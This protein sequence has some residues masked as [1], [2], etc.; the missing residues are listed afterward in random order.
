M[1]AADGDAAFDAAV[2][3]LLAGDF[4][5][6]APLFHA[7]SGADGT[8]C[9]I[10]DWDRQ[11]RFREQPAARA[12]AL[13]CACFLGCMPVVEYL[14]DHGVAA[15]GGAATGLDGLHWAVNRGQ[16]DVVRCLL[17][18]KVGL[19]TRSMYGGTPIG[20]VLWSARNEPR[21]GHLAIL[22][23]LLEAGASIDAGL[24]P[25]GDARIDALLERHGARG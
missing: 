14:L 20:T 15:P 21:A 9:A 18:R 10:L 12:E 22:A 16:L 1:S 24:Y 7:R 17:A 23:A 4:S 11:G 2:L 13:T 5:R 6:L 25:T 8:R 3:G 19:E